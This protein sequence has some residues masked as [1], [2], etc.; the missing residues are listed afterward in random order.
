MVDGVP[1]DSGHTEATETEVAT[2]KPGSPDEEMELSERLKKALE[3][4]E[5]IRRAS[6]PGPLSGLQRLD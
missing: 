5:R 2:E 3:R 6:K 4:A 1:S